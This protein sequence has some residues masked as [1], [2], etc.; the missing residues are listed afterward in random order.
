M[1]KTFR[2]AFSLK[3]TY[4]VNGILFGLKQI[5]LIK[6]ILPQSLYRVQGLKIFANILAALW[7]IFMAF[8]GKAFYFALMIFL[9]VAFFEKQDSATLFLHIYVFLTMI[10]AFGNTYVFNPSRD[11]YYAMV[12]MRMDA[13]E[14][15]LSYY[16]YFLLK[17]AVGYLAFGA[18]FGS[19]M[20]LNLA[21]I[22]LLPVSVVGSKCFMMG[23]LLCRYEKTGIAPN[24]NRGG[25]VYWISMGVLLALAY[26]LPFST[27]ILPRS[28][29]VG[30]LCLFAVSGLIFVKKI[31]KFPQYYEVQKEILNP[32][33]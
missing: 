6:K 17:M 22:I 19:L 18:L 21:E 23:A 31:V 28:V 2:I 25:K 27:F 11:K 20:G 1:N 24:E 5:P 29:S 10:G 13:K 30:V 12:L 4:R 26:G 16:V 9:P 8:A 14:Y 3:N 32:N 15:T 7:E 33:C